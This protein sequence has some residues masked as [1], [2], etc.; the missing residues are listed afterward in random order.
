MEKRHHKQTALSTVIKWIILV[1]IAVIQI[2]PLIWLFDFSFAS[3]QELF[4]GGLFI[5]PKVI[6]WSNYSKAFTQGKILPYFKNSL[7]INILAVVIV[8]FFAVLISFACTRMKWKL[9][10]TVRNIILLGLMIPIHATLLPNFKVY[11]TLHMYDTMWALLV[12]YVA[13]S[14]PQAL[15]L[16][17][18]FMESIPREIEEAAVMDGCGIYRI[19]F[20]VVAPMLRPSLATVAIMT[21]LNNWNEFIMGVIYLRTDKWKTLPFS[22]V[23]FIGQYTTDYSLQFAVMALSALPAI[24]IYVLLS[25]HIIKGVVAGAV[26]G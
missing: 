12:P 22:V 4:K 2:Y 3:N 5:I 25:K 1:V 19:I 17:S 13:F 14:M 23:N 8:L 15:F 26:K 7:I 6:K 21:F 16:I 9:R 10:G 20:T 11:T 18:G 24:L